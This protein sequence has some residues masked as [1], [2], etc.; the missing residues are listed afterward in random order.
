MRVTVSK[1]D[2]SNKRTSTK[3][4]RRHV[5]TRSALCASAGEGSVLSLAL[6]RLTTEP[7]YSKFLQPHNEELLSEILNALVQV[8]YRRGKPKSPVPTTKEALVV[9]M[10]L[11]GF[12]PAEDFVIDISG[13]DTNMVVFQN[14]KDASL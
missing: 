3:H 8:F 13:T 10:E 1:V 7:K 6:Y 14:K 4:S 2:T 12:T 5:G 9:A 11:L